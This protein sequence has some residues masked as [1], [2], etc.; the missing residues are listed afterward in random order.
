MG[1][2]LSYKILES[3]Y[4]GGLIKRGVE[5]P[6]AVD[7]VLTTDTLGIISF[8]YFE[9]M[10]IPRIR[11]KLAVCYVDHN[12]MQ[13]GPESAND[14]LF[15]KTFASKFGLYFSKPGNGICHQL[16]VERFGIP[17]DTL[18]GTDS[19]TPTAGGLGM[20]GIGVGGL[21]VTAV[22]A[23]SPFYLTVPEIM[24][25]ELNGKLPQWTSAK[26]ISLEVL[27]RL[28]VR[29]GFGKILEYDGQGVGSL[30]VPER[31]TIANLGTETGAT[32]SLFPSDPLTR[33][34]LQTQGR[35]EAW[36]ELEAD[37]DA[38]YDEVMEIDL[39]EIEPLVA[40]PHSPGNVVPVKELE[41]L[42]I[43]QVIIGSC[44]NS[45]L[46]DLTT[47]AH[48]L[49][50]RKIHPG[51]S[52]AISPGSRLGLHH[53]AKTGLLSEIIKS[54][55]RI[56][57][58]VCGPCIGLGQAP[59]SGGISLRT[60]NRNFKGRSGTPD[61]HVYLVSPETAAASALTG[62]LTDPRKLTISPIISPPDY[63]PEADD[64]I[65]PPSEHPES[66]TIIRGPN[67]KPLG[68]F[69]SM[70]EGFEVKVLLKLGDDVTTDLIVPAGSKAMPLRSNI[71]A[72]SEYTFEAADPTFARRARKEKGGVIV[73]GENYGQ[74]SSREHA[75][76][77]PR[78]LG[79]RVILAKSF[80]RIHMNNLI[81]FGI[82]PLTIVE[83]GEYEKL[84][85]GDV[86]IFREV[87]K[88]V[89]KKD[90]LEIENSTKGRRFST[91]A[92]LTPRQ[93]GILL[94]GGLINFVRRH[95]GS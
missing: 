42:K 80:A 51:V 44:T 13:M 93:R 2:S 34:Y 48:I 8:L 77:C 12:T 83:Q 28:G 55:A 5:I 21:D 9:S 58:P 3:H 54:G 31:A 59:P 43:D 6:L 65:L 73:A 91:S 81:N 32:S 95:P 84:D 72:L 86:L 41:G 14:H 62:E 38:A 61:A 87:R 60:F 71:P 7:Q 69:G 74:G 30:S 1:K 82:L 45:S 56:L 36:R 25:V 40:K 37:P 92:N 90:I 88:A 50:S 24:L 78:Y 67:I 49:K 76:L 19:H 33:D 68:V 47:V 70:E 75:A 57:E 29:G 27:R 39:D 89:E 79:V 18:I 4:G 64:M 94:E 66:V 22:M 15:L 20:L 26:D 35:V 23:G 16:H 46:R 53:L 63:A 52:V 85:Q 11:T 10:N 17:G